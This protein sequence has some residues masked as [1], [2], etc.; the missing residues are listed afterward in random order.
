MNQDKV[1]GKNGFKVSEVKTMHNCYG[2]ISLYVENEQSMIF[3]PQQDIV[4]YNQIR[5]KEINEK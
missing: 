3:L 1:F 2:K 5:D 4:Q